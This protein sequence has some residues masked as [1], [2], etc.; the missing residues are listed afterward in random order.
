MEYKAQ[1][2]ESSAGVTAA[3]T[4]PPPN[5]AAQNRDYQAGCQLFFHL[6]RGSGRKSCKRMCQRVSGH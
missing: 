4:A 1:R 2:T 3:I 5:F 6:Q